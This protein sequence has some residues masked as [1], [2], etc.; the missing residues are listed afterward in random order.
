MSVRVLVVDDSRFFRKRI[1]AILKVDETIEIVGFAVNGK[2]A[3]EM[4]T[5]LKPDVITMDVEMPVM[6]GITAVRH[7]MRRK[8]VPILMF[9][10]LTTNGAQSTLDA[11][12]AGA[13]D[14][15]PKRFEDISS[16]SDDAQRMLRRRV[17]EIARKGHAINMRVRHVTPPANSNRSISAAARSTLTSP[18]S[19]P[20]S[21]MPIRSSSI[22]SPQQKTA[23]ASTLF[24]RGVKKL[25][26]IKLLAIGTSTGGPVAL[27]NL[28]T[29]LPADFPLP[30][31][32]VQHMPGTFT[33]AF[34]ERLNQV[35][36]ISVKEARS[37]DVLQPGVALLAP[38]GMQMTIAR[39]GSQYIVKVDAGDPK[40]NYKPSVDV[41]FS[42]I[43]DNFKGR[44]LGVILTGMG[45][46]GR[47]GCRALK[48]K[49]AAIWAQ[50]E[51]SSVV[52]GMPFAVFEA[53]LTDRVFP[54]TEIGPAILQ[55]V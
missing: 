51:Q 4:A 21:Q 24:R 44:T 28:L 25:A 11:L 19:K 16:N 43:A 30:I 31:V 48:Q 1:E 23:T 17:K 33:P 2:E 27:Q 5:K 15:I 42:S 40:L 3:V 10:S 46:D 7:I 39:R 36:A 34:A 29:A 54:L 52:Y 8:P 22:A 32:M 18:R 41:T 37:G 6:D 13:L 47:E 9:S 45:A 53:G 50:D 14:F 20:T 49:E 38:G 26:G 35:C 55:G 12:D